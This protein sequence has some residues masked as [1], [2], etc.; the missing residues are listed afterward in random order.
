MRLGVRGKL[1]GV[2]VVLILVMGLM[3]TLL[4]ET[5]LVGWMTERTDARLRAHVHSA[6]EFVER[7]PD[8][9]TIQNSDPVI[10]RFADAIQAR[11]T[12][13]RRDGVVLGDSSVG[14]SEVARME[15]HAARPEVIAALTEGVGTARRFSDTIHHETLYVAVP[16]TRAEADGV[17]RV[18]LTLEEMDD[19]LDTLRRVINYGVLVGLIVAILMS[20]LASHLLSRTLRRLAQAVRLKSRGAKA[21]D[22]ETERDEVELLALTLDNLSVEVEE[23]VGQLAEERARVNAVLE[24]MQEA[25]IAVDGDLN[26]TLVNAAAKEMFDLPQFTD[27]RSLI[28]LLR[29]PELNDY[30]ESGDWREQGEGLE[31]QIEGVVKRN[32]LA[33][34]T[35]QTPGTGLVVVCHDITRLRQLE[36]MR[37]DFVANVS[38]ELRTPVSAIQGGAENLLDGAMEDPAVSVRFLE[39]IA[40]NAERLGRLISELID[41]NRIESGAHGLEPEAIGV[42]S[43]LEGVLQVLKLQVE[44]K[45]ITI[46]KEV[47]ESPQVW[48]DPDALEQI[49]FN[50]IENAVK[51]VPEEGNVFV[52]VKA[53]RSRVMFEIADDGP[54]VPKEHHG[55]LFE[56]FYRV[57]D[58]RS[59]AMGGTGLGLAIVK[60]LVTSMG[61]RIGIRE[62][63]QQGSIFHF[64]LPLPS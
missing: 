2:S 54:G 39:S 63:D 52:R 9:D 42:N 7:I 48:A 45:H 62:A 10:D 40:R 46:H 14:T 28:E 15:N 26:V 17:I 57:D 8:L 33:R 47:A 24:A 19:V 53:T 34:I 44:E 56:R 11:V 6:R 60:H 41:L 51:Y 12:Y 27:R 31:L 43:A 38:H 23:S 18:S 20:G 59:R 22:G 36:G 37:S 16:F 1:F 25:I 13:I 21:G 58:G 30:I 50:L 32:V 35:P 3:G 61:G 49:L 55:R 29:L 4:F 5:H 64:D